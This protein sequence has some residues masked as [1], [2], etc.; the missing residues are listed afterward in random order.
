MEESHLSWFD[1]DLKTPPKY[2]IK[3]TKFRQDSYTNNA[4]SNLKTLSKYETKSTKFQQNSYKNIII[5][6]SQ[7]S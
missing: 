7:L 4:N 5:E 3:S 6:E 1:S 2:E